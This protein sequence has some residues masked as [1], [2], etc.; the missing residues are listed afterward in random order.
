MSDLKDDVSQFLQRVI[1]MESIK[2]HKWSRDYQAL[3][4]LDSLETGKLLT[5]EELWELWDEHKNKQK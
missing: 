5:D 1:K 3:H 2:F 4:I